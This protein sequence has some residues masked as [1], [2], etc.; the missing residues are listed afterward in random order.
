VSA[1]VPELC[2]ALLRE[3]RVVMADD[4]VNRQAP[5]VVLGEVAADVGLDAG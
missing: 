5:R 1:S 3:P 4:L 2:L